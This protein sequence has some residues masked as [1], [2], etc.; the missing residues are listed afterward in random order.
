MTPSQV[1]EKNAKDLYRKIY[2]L[3]R[4]EKRF[5]KMKFKIND[6]VRKSKYKHFFEKGYTPYLITKI[7]TIYQIN[8]TSPITYLSKDYENNRIKG[9][10]YKAELTKAK[11]PELSLV[12]KLIKTKENKAFVKWL[13]FYESHNS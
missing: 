10:F 9:C 6:K 3:I 4:V 7:L 2:N 1:N 5:K 12:L 11:N 13:G 8:N